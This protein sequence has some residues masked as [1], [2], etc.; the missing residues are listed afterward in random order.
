MA[1]YK[2][3][4]KNSQGQTVTGSTEAATPGDARRE[5]RDKGLIPIELKTGAASGKRQRQKHGKGGRIKL[6]DLVIFSRQIAVMIR[7]GLP[8]LE[9]LNILQEQME[10]RKF[11]EVLTVVEHD[12]KG[13]ASLTERRQVF[14]DG[15]KKGDLVYLPRYRRR[16]PVHKVNRGKGE[17]VV[18]LGAMKLTVSFDE[19]TL[20]ESL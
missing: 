14:L 2:Y 11:K 17:V 10:K 9:V 12:V 16:V 15:M 3:V 18:K 8:L 1:V 13:G 20:Y 7:A 4:A 19:V 6:D 5:L